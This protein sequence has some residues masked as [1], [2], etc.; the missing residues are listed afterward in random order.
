ME[1]EFGKY[2]FVLET[3][4]VCDDE[5][6]LNDFLERFEEGE[7]ISKED[8]FEFRKEYIDDSS[9]IRYI[10]Q[11]WNYILSEGKL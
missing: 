10:K 3:I 4:D 2:E 11:D 5:D 9:E 1:K 7:D 8:Y 6:M